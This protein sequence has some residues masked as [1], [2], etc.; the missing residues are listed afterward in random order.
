[1]GLEE[2]VSPYG[3]LCARERALLI[4]DEE[5]WKRAAFHVSVRSLSELSRDLA[6]IDKA[7]ADLWKVRAEFRLMLGHPRSYPA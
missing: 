2:I 6:E 1:M 7:W 5:L 4:R 3:V